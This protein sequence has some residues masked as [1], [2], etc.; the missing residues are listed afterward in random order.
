M[1]TSTVPAAIDNLIALIEALP[2][3]TGDP[4]VLVADG[5]PGP[6]N[7]DKIIT[8]GGTV[9]PT[10]EDEQRPAQLGAQRR[11]EDYKIQGVVS[12]YGGRGSQQKA[13]R[14]EAYALFGAIETMLREQPG[15]TLNAT[16]TFAQI[17]AHHLMQTSIDNAQQ[18]SLAE[19]TFWVEV[20]AYI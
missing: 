7:P 10:A 11:R 16:V 4:D 15:A 19:I 5:Y 14:D 12:V 13:T 9:E 8:I 20:F 3:V 2:A 17:G 18:G 1:A 6:E